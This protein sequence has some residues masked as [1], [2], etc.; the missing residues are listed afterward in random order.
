VGAGIFLSR[1]S[2]FIRERAFAFFFGSSEFAD[3]WRAA[4]RM[5]NVV[6]NLLGEGTLSASFIPIYAELLEEGRDEEA[7]RFAG[8]VLGLLLL[9]VATVTV[10]GIL[11]APLVV[12]IFFFRWSPEKQTLTVTLV[13]IL[14]PMTAVLV[15]S[16][17]ALGVLNSHRRFFMSY[18]APVMWNLAMI[19]TL[20]G[21]GGYAAFG[22]RDL[23]VALAWGAVVGALLQLGVQLPVVIVVLRH[24]RLSAS[25][26]VYG[27]KEA[28]QNFVPVLTARGVVNVSGYLDLVLAGMLAGG[29][30][31]MLGYAQTFYLLPISLFGMSVAASELPE[32]SRQRRDAGAVV[33]Q[34]VSRA[35][36]TLAWFLVPS[37]LA[38]ILLG[39][40][41]IAALY[42][43]G[44]FGPRE[45]AV[46]HA[47]L[48]AYSLGLL[49]SARSRMLSSAFY[50]L[51]DT[52]T[53]ARIAYVRVVLS[54]AVGAALMFPFDRLDVD[55]LHLGA[56]GLALGTSVAAWFEY[57]ALRLRLRQ[58]VGHHAAPRRTVLVAWSVGLLA[59]GAG[60][61]TRAALPPLHPIWTAAGTLL[62][63]GGVYLAGTRV[64]GAPMPTGR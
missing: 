4:L 50:A 54:L 14:F 5:P 43:T 16:A 47:V 23:V 57:G 27:V 58:A 59:A 10:V 19:A 49:A 28:I 24:F 17:W 37:T 42:Q 51:R 52:R 44:S 34:R 45:T 1:V 15:L 38:Y 9:T 31:A 22:Q 53:P 62:V 21:L 63:F 3:A 26:A 25:R 13:Q 30:V 8:A 11:L 36:G 39:D 64:L 46:T 12:P 32:L 20:V 2:G 33:S 40:V 60:W 48:A 35:L 41:I 29:A 6:Q 7:G 61:A 56:A 18:V 55:G